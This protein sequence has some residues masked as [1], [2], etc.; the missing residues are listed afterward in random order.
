MT[1][2]KSIA[3]VRSI[4]KKQ[5]LKNKI[6]GFVPTM[7]ALHQGHLSLIK[8]ARKDA[9]FLVVSIFVNPLQFGPK[10]DYR[11]YPRNFKKDRALLEKERVDLIFYPYP[12]NMYTAGFSTYVEETSLSKSLCGKSRPGHF[13]GVA[14]VVTKL[15]NIVQPDIAYF[16]R[17]DYQ[18]AQVI[19]RL[20]QDL[21]IPAQIRILPIIRQKSGLALSSRNAYLSQKE[22][23]KALV[24][25][26]SLRLARNLVKQGQRKPHFIKTKIAKLINSRK[27]LKIDYIELVDP[28]TLKPVKKIDKKTLLALAIFV[29]KIRLI[30]NTI[31]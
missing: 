4:I 25:Y 22:E 6:I 14:T 12:K 21:N 30:D 24:L 16:G 11:I 26:Q 2:T 31:I 3:K 1:I 17:K 19:K 10:E 28:K 29:G 18:Q 15:F 23:K 13:R 8:K 20:T 5:K 27:N 7:G 9:G